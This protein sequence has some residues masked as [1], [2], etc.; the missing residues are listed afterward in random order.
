MRR[1]VAQRH[2]GIEIADRA[3]RLLRRVHAL[4]L[5]DDDDGVGRLNELNRAAPRHVVA[6]PVDDI[7]LLQLIL[8][9]LRKLFVGNILLKR[10]DVDDHYLNL[11]AADELPHPPKPL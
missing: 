2:H 10:L 6:L 9:H 1:A 11:V 5:V 4:G 3:L 7:E 8:G